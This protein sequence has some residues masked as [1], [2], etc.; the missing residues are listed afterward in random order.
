MG[1]AE[2]RAEEVYAKDKGTIMEA[3]LSGEA[4]IKRWNSI[5][6]EQR[7][8]ELDVHRDAVEAR[9]IDSLAERYVPVGSP[10]NR[11]KVMLRVLKLCTKRGDLATDLREEES[12]YRKSIA[13]TVL[14]HERDTGLGVTMTPSK[15]R[16]N[17]AIGGTTAYENG[18]GVHGL[19]GV[20]HRLNGRERARRSN[21][22][23]Y[24][25]PMIEKALHLSKD[26]LH[27]HTKGP[28]KGKPQWSEIAYLVSKEFENRASGK[29]LSTAVRRFKER[30]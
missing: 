4:R 18:N 12:R 11:R 30:K 5:D 22:I 8:R 16:E 15:I 26:G 1:W 6:G 29:T 25:D 28:N 7:L 19:D 21:Q 17:A 14:Y 23:I 13:A 24:T 9:S 2:R 20:T 27:L 3:Y 10:T